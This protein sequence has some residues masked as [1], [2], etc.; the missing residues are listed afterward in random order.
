[1]RTNHCHNILPD[2]V[3]G[4]LSNQDAADV[5][6]HLRQCPSCRG[7]LEEVRHVLETIQHAGAGSVP[8]SYFAS[9]LP[10]VHQRLDGKKHFE[11]GKSLVVNKLLFP[12]GVAVVAAILIW[13]IPLPKSTRGQVDPLFAVV[14]SATSEDIGEILQDEMTLQDRSSLDTVILSRALSDDQFV[15]RELVQEALVG[16]T[17][18]PFEVFSDVSPQQVL[19][20]FDESDTNE[21]LQQLGHME[22]L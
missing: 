7:E 16:E 11:W 22:T 12:L 9:I 20:G 18:S 10:R 1:M 19:S 21:L 2:Y 15:E 4:V 8:K 13:H 6:A 17:T 3:R 5:E 14:D